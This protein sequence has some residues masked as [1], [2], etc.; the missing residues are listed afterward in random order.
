MTGS[1]G[2]LKEGIRTVP[3]PDVT[4]TRQRRLH[5]HC[6]E[7]GTEPGVRRGADQ[8][9]PMMAAKLDYRWHLRHLMADRG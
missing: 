9:G 4:I 8:E 2:R 1:T 5:E 6:S 3:I 7:Q